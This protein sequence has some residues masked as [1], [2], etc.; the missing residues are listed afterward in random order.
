MGD[1]FDHK[2]GV[3]TPGRNAPTTEH[4]PVPGKRTLVDVCYENG[5]DPGILQLLEHF[6]E[7]PPSYLDDL[8]PRDPEIAKRRIA[9]G[10]AR[11]KEVIIGELPLGGWLVGTRG[12]FQNAV[13]RDEQQIASRTIDAARSTVAGAIAAAAGTARGESS[14]LI[15]RR[16][17]AAAAVEGAL[18]A[19]AA[20]AQPKYQPGGQRETARGA[21]LEPQARRASAAPAPPQPGPVHSEL[22]KISLGTRPPAPPNETEPI[23]LHPAPRPPT[24]KVPRAPEPKV[25]YPSTPQ[26]PGQRRNEGLK[27]ELKRRSVTTQLDGTDNL[28]FDVNTP[29]HIVEHFKAE[30]ERTQSNDASKWRNPPGYE[31]QHPNGRPYW[32]YGEP[33]G[34]KLH[35]GTA[36]DN[37][38]QNTRE[39]GKTPRK[40]AK[41]LP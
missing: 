6:R 38:I 5:P 16:A 40:P 21:T 11:A 15:M 17:E 20:T 24:K 1:G 7:R 14:I 34:T 26:G 36:A 19:V 37:S 39:L 9:E 35:W 29:M 4:A 13:R 12:D 2:K 41:P 30:Q 23:H 18:M 28:D 32:E 31:G 33:A 10:M 3:A 27:T 25:V 8:L 22:P